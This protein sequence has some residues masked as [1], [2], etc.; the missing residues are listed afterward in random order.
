MEET[1]GSISLMARCRDWEV[2]R[3]ASVNETTTPQEIAFAIAGIKGALDRKTYD[4][5]GLKTGLID[6]YAA[7]LS[8]GRRK[9]WGAVG[10]IFSSLKP[11][12]IS[13]QLK[14][15]CP[16]EK[17]LPVAEAYLLHALLSSIGFDVE[18]S[19]A[20]LSKIYPELKIAKPRGNFKGKKKK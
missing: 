17:L 4:F 7:T 20:I 11:G 6:E 16:D 3:K 14:A 2:V 19:Q 15:A 18:P 12:E 9:S 10:E 1:T 13:A 8:K 5:L